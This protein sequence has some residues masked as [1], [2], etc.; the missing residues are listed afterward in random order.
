MA[1]QAEG[2]GTETMSIPFDG[3]GN[4]IYYSYTPGKAASFCSWTKPWV[5]S[6]RPGEARWNK[7]LTS[8]EVRQLQTGADPRTVAPDDLYAY[9]PLQPE[10]SESNWI[11]KRQ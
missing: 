8:E 6:L 4:E 10:I 7:A 11:V 5:T 2:E 1:R 3:T 9:R